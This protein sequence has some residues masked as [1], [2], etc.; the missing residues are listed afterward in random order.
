LRIFTPLSN[1]MTLRGLLCSAL[2]LLGFFVASH[3]DAA[4]SADAAPAIAAAP[5]LDD[6]YPARKTEFPDGVTGIADIVYSTL[7]GFRPLTLDIYIPRG[8]PNQQ[9]NP[10]VIYVHGGGWTSGHTRHSGAFEDWPNVLASL[11]ARGYVVSSLNYRLSRE[12]PF[13]AA[14]HDVKTAIRW[15]RSR[16][17]EF[18]IDKTRVLVWGGSAGGQLIALAATSCAAQELAPPSSSPESDCV[19]GA[20]AWYGVFNFSTIPSP[21]GEASASPLARY[22]GC[23]FPK[24]PEN[25]VRL[26]SPIR[27]VDSS[28]P[29]MLLIHGVNDRVVPVAQSRE[30][31]DALKKAGVRVDTL[32]IPDVDHSFV[33]ATHETTRR[34]SLTAIEATFSFIDETLKPRR[35]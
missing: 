21:A 23:P 31:S 3:G 11:A 34:A 28:D 6:R 16:A 27:F 29:P 13:P 8:A 18:G 9:K 19:Q 24:C 22:L 5:V 32:L 25:T 12:A 2:S 7:D 4:S 35:E 14:I 10:L 15:L 20:V 30:F 17:S 26:A 33:G 1:A